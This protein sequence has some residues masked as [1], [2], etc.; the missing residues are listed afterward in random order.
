MAK[1]MN[2]ILRDIARN[3]YQTDE[4]EVDEKP[5][6]SP[7]SDGGT[8]VAAWVWVSDAMVDTYKKA[9]T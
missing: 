2:E 9:Q 4:I 8:W 5:A 3:E 1:K 7:S 6:L